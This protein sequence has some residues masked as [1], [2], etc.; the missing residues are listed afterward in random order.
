MTEIGAQK[1]TGLPCSH[2]LS[3]TTSSVAVERAEI[4][5]MISGLLAELQVQHRETMKFINT[6]DDSIVR[7]IMIYRHIDL[8]KS[9]TKISWLVYGRGDKGNSLKSIYYRFLKE[10]HMK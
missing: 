4:A 1:I 3:D 9:W 10:N 2:T 5:D 6:L 8:L 7:Q